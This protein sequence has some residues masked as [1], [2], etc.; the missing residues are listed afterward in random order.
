M[1]YRYR[2][3]YWFSCGMRVSFFILNGN[4]LQN[5]VVDEFITLQI[6]K[7]ILIL[8]WWKTLVYLR[9]RLGILD[10]VALYTSN[11]LKPNGCL[12][13]NWCLLKRSLKHGLKFYF[14]AMRW[15][16]FNSRYWCRRSDLAFRGSDTMDVVLNWMINQER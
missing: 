1:L 9:L 6:A 4:I 10:Y 12:H 2:A 16:A 14:V 11:F 3:I 8:K 13:L 7:N 15:A 5:L